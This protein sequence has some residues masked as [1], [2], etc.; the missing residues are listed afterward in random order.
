MEESRM[1]SILV[2]RDIAV[3]MRDGVRLATDVYR[4]EG[5][6]NCPTLVHRNPY[7]KSSAGSVGGLIVNPLDAVQEGSR[8]SSRTSAGGSDPRASGY[9]S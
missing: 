6:E 8:S 5:A 3:E 7:N 1:D 4:P 9:R 2:E